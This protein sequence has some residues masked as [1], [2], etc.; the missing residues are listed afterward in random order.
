LAVT[1]VQY[2]IAEP[3]QELCCGPFAGWPKPST[4]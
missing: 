1:I 4:D 2:P 3:P